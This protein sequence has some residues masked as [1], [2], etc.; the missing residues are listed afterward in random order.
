MKETRNCPTTTPEGATNVRLEQDLRQPKMASSGSF[1]PGPS[2][3]MGP[4]TSYDCRA[5]GRSMGSYVQE[6]ARG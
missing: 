2:T 4:G 5:H 1:H 3:I 6:W